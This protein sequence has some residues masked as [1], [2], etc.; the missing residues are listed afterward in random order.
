VGTLAPTGG[1]AAAGAPPL[2][3]ALVE[4]REAT[5]PADGAEP[6]HWRLWTT[7]P[8]ATLAATRAVVGVYEL[9]PRVEDFH[10][11]LKSG[12]RV[13]ALALE[14]AERLRKALTIYSG[15]AARILGL[16][17]RARREPGAPCTEALSEDEWR[18]LWALVR[19]APPAPAQ[20]P[21]TLAEA[22]A[23][24]GRLGGHLGRKCDGPPGVRTLWRGWRDLQLLVLGYRAA[25]G[26]V[27]EA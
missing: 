12:C 3:F 27:A 19:G 13:E 4:A 8:A 14:T 11:T 10:L 15:I 22:S 18:A 24:L 20:P 9:R 6:L 2:T 17:D 5:P 25:R 21:P 16:R 26:T 7:E 23:W 1:A